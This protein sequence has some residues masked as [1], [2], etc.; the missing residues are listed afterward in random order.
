MKRILLPTDFSINAYNAIS[1]AF[2]LFKNEACTFYLLHTYTPA[3]YQTEYVLH[4][5]GQIGLGDV[6]QTEAMEQMEE[7][8]LQLEREF[9]NSNHTI[10]THVAF[11]TLVDEIV[12]SSEHEHADYIV[13]GTKGA[14]GAKEVFL[15]T[16]AVHVI[17]KSKVPV[18]V[19]PDNFEFEKPGAILFPTDLEVPYPPE[20]VA[21]IVTL[22]KSHDSSVEVLHISTGYELTPEQ[23]E[24]KQQ[25]KNSLSDVTHK[26]HSTSS[27]PIIEGISKFQMENP[28]N[29]LAMIRN[30]HTFLERLFIEPVIQ[31]IGYHVSIPF[32]VIP[33]L[34]DE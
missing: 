12:D 2:N 24:K 1:Y 31:K 11:N 26:Y 15:G 25:L 14:T 33:K 20:Q 19:V 10:M 8:K 13:M 9:A 32:M 30:K 34:E 7:L 16:H 18:I 23:K 27:Q 17:N 28:M 21:P 3:V 6:Y 29:L 5:P 22:A 4:S